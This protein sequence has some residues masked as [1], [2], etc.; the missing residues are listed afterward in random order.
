[1]YTVGRQF[2]T[3]QDGKLGIEWRE[4]LGCGLDD[5]DLDTLSDEVLCH[6]QADEPCA[7]HDSRLR[8]HIDVG[9]QTCSV[10]N[11]PEGPDPLVA[12]NGRSYRGRPHA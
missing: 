8:R 12:R 10:L 5:G 1:M 6:L 9:C 11:R 3:D 2:I 4:D 7:D